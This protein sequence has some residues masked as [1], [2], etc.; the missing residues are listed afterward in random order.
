LDAA[1]LEQAA[2]AGAVV[3][4]GRR[5]ETVERDGEGWI[6][7][8]DSERRIL[9]SQVFLCSG[10]HDVRGWRRPPGIQS[11]L[12]AFKLHWRLTAEQHAL[13]GPCVEL[14]VFE[15]GYGGLQPIEDGLVNLCLLVR[16]QRLQQLGGWDE[17]LAAIQAECPHLAIRL[18]GAVA[19]WARPLALSAIPYGYV[20]AR[21]DGLW[22]LGDQAAVIPSFSG[23]GISIALHSA[24]LAAQL[25]LSGGSAAD[26]QRLLQQDIAQQ[27]TVAT[28]ISRTMV[29]APSMLMAVARLWPGVLRLVAQQTRIH[30]DAVRRWTPKSAPC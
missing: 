22:R 17:L 27:V 6:A 12:I 26:F 28:T 10:K 3:D 25:F 16:R 15:G 5:V 13:L 1:L 2:A 19:S 9:A 30:A 20:A 14:I 7:R 21:S 8:L 18:G 4:L 23:D 24:R 11:D 29:A